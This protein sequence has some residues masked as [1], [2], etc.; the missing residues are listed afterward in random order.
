MH[1]NL[2]GGLTFDWEVAESPKD[3]SFDILRSNDGLSFTKLASVESKYFAE[4]I[5]YTFTDETAQRLNHSVYYRI[6]Q[7]DQNGKITFSKIV[8][9][10]NRSQLVTITPN[11]VLSSTTVKSSSAIKQLIITD[12]AGKII[13]TINANSNMVNIN[14][15]SIPPGIYMVNTI[16]LSGESEILRIVKD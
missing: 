5:R 14:L 9:V 11:P 12:V 15:S 13:K 1:L 4:P 2:Q 7:K 3:G 6:S 10:K 8:S 16:L